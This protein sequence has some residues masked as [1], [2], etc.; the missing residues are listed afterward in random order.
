[1]SDGLSSMGGMSGFD[2]DPLTGVVIGIAFAA[3]FAGISAAIVMCATRLRQQVSRPLPPGLANSS[4]G[5]MLNRT[6]HNR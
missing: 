2:L 5:S 6:S 3:G 4:G 1:M